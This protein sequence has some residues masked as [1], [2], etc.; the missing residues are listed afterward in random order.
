MKPVQA[1]VAFFI[2]YQTIIGNQSESSGSRN[3]GTF[4]LALLFTIFIPLRLNAWAM[5]KYRKKKK[6]PNPRVTNCFGFFNENYNPKF[7]TSRIIVSRR[8]A[9]LVLGFSWEEFIFSFFIATIPN[10]YWF[11]ISMIILVTLAV[12]VITSRTQ[13]AFDKYLKVIRKCEQNDR[14]SAAMALEL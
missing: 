13:D 7:T 10:N 2:N 8:M 1:G 11:R 12:V 9:Q 6:V 14:K 5:L 3:A 4:L